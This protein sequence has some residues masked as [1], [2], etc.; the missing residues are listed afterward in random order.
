MEE[1]IRL[2][3]H[4]PLFRACAGWKAQDLA[5]KLD[6]SRQT[7][8]AWET[9]D[10]NQPKKGVRM[11]VIQYYAVRKILDDEI[12]KDV[13]E[14]GESTK[15]HI[16]GTLLEVLVDHPNLYS[17]EDVNAALEQANAVAPVIMTKPER[18]K[19][20]SKVWPALVAGG[21]IA[22]SAALIAILGLEIKGRD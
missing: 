14:S 7:I 16:L 5:D 3:R 8:S 10:E 9:Y 6:V 12:A 11:T 21:G 17:P 2:Q 13:S 15:Q 19:S 4:L 18:R 1:P 20:F 22:I